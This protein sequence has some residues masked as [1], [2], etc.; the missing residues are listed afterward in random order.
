M[1]LEILPEAKEDIVEALLWYWTQQPGLEDR[2]E[3]ALDQKMA[4]LSAFPESAPVLFSSY[5][6]ALIGDFPYAIVYRIA[7]E[8]LVV[9]AVWQSARDPLALFSRL[10]LPGDE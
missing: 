4:Q 10:D 9:R 7:E 3:S 1:R 8:A 6:V 5:R 2:F